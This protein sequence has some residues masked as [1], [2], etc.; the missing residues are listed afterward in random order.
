MVLCLVN[1]DIFFLC[2]EGLKCAMNFDFIF[3]FVGGDAVFG[4]GAMGED[5][6]RDEAMIR[7]KPTTE[8]Q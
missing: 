2:F 6:G 4:F 1:V 3:G 5:K 8:R 7:A